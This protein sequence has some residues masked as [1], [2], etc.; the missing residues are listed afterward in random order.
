MDLT[1]YDDKALELLSGI[2]QDIAAMRWAR[3]WNAPAQ[4]QQAEQALRRARALRREIN[5]RE[6]QGNGHGRRT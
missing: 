6:R 3:A 1:C 2:Q 4:R 5:R